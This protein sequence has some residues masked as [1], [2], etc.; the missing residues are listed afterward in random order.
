MVEWPLTGK[1]P[2]SLAALLLQKESQGAFS[3]YRLNQLDENPLSSAPKKRKAEGRLKTLCARKWGDCLGCLSE[4]ICRSLFPNT[5]S[6]RP[7]VTIDS[8]QKYAK[9]EQ[10]ICAE[11]MSK[12]AS[13]N[14]TV[15]S[16][17][18]PN[19]QPSLS[20]VDIQL[21]LPYT[22]RAKDFELGRLNRQAFPM[23]VILEGSNVIE[24]LKSLIPL[25][26]TGPTGMPKFLTEL[27]SMATNSL[28]VDVDEDDA[29]GEKYRVTTG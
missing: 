9:G 29:S 3:R 21:N 22:S 6:Y 14:R 2:T 15:A 20:R 8:L 16:E 5:D 27:H 10:D 12:I 1:S 25:G 17:F 19:A 4:M 11:D 23:K 26:M 28:T 13:R 24:G 7:I 18:G